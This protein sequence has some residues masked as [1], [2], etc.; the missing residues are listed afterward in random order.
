MTSGPRMGIS[1]K[2][3]FT[4]YVLLLATGMTFNNIHTYLD[5]VNP[6]WYR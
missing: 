2:A 4:V 6:Y 5:I 1:K 3:F